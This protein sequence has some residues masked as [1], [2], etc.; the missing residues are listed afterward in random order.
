MKEIKLWKVSPDGKGKHTAEQLSNVNQTETENQLEEIIVRC[1]ELLMS[2][3]KLVGR[4]TAASGGALDLLGLDGDGRMVV[5]ELKR[6]ILTRDAIAQIIDYASYLSD[7][8]TDELIS[9]ISERSGNLGVD[10][11]ENFKSWYQ[12]QFAKEITTLQKPR[13][14]LVGLGADDRARRMVSFLAQSDIDI[15]L[16]TFH[17]FEE[18]GKVF[19]ARQVEVAAKY[20][21]GTTGTTKKDSLEKL[22]Q[23]VK[24]LGI[25]NYYYKMSAFFRDQLPAYE[26][27]YPGGFSY[28]LQE[29]TETGSASLRVYITLYLIPKSKVR[30]QIHHRAIEGITENIDPIIKKLSGKQRP[31]GGI[32]ILVPTEQEWE[33]L[34][35][36]FNE[37]CPLILAGWKEKREQHV[38]EEFKETEA[39]FDFAAALPPDTKK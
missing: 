36:I 13:M 33:K 20:Q 4:Q 9:H 23:K 7:L 31:D 5:F 27:P 1:P 18:A 34:M 15:S 12:E 24:E 37:L 38:T 26:W 2:D 35:P 8:G 11:I 30:I 10:K 6:G 16:I 14:A 39:E 32:E 19:L 21:T 28:S 29:I 22:Q 3:L 17:G 25:E